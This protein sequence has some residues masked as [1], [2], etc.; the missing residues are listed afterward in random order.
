MSPNRS[1]YG[2]PASRWGALLPLNRKYE[3]TLV[4]RRLIS[5]RVLRVTLSGFEL[6]GFR[7]QGGDQRCA[8]LIPWPE[9]E[10][11]RY[12]VPMITDPWSAAS[13][14]GLAAALTRPLRRSLTVS[15]Y[16][17]EE[18][19]IDFDILLHGD[20]PLSIWAE[21]AQ[22]GSTVEVIDNGRRYH[23]SDRT[24]WQLLIADEAGAPAA[25]AV[26][27]ETP[28]TVPTTLYIP[29][30]VEATGTCAHSDHV[31]VVSVSSYGER[32]ASGEAFA[33]AVLA[34]RLPV[35]PDRV[36]IAGERSFTHT[37][38]TRLRRAGVPRNAIQ[39]GSYWK[40]R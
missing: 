18:L 15:G 3:L 12:M 21:G 39:A 6:E 26:A 9:E 32:R 20:T 19:E 13:Q 37:L 28:A 27:A 17:A 36:G 8:L 35:V 29:R 25:V 34:D 23:V 7:Y 2:R 40:R 14:W 1:G 5:E 4:D 22:F 30:T 24:R 16:R 31:T 33:A 38:V 10:A 11:W